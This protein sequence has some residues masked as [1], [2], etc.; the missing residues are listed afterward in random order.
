MDPL[1]LIPVDAQYGWI[2]I[3]LLVLLHEPSCQRATKLV[4]S[5][6]RR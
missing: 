1:A 5:C 4:R 2:C 3:L 6:R